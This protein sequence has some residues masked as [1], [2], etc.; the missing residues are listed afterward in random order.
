MSSARGA[1]EV[2]GPACAPSRGQ[3]RPAHPILTPHPTPTPTPGVGEAGGRALTYRPPG[4]RGRVGKVSNAPGREGALEMRCGRRR[5]PP[6]RPRP[7]PPSQSGPGPGRPCNA[8]PHPAG[9]PAAPPQPVA[10]RADGAQPGREPWRGAP[11]AQP[12][13]PALGPPAPLPQLFSPG[14]TLPPTPANPGA[15]AGGG[16][17]PAAARA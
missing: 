13:V 9:P 14:D 17:P 3:L 8:D 16:G 10:G 15:G 11:S 2:G 5:P 7:P 4:R 6:P 12:S 1:L